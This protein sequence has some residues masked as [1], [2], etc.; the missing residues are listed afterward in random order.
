[1]RMLCSLPVALSLALTFMIPLASTSNVTSIWGIPRGAGAIPSRWN[2]PKVLQSRAIGRSPCSTWISTLGWLSAAVENTWLLRVGIV[3]L[4]SM[5]LVITPPRV[6]IP[7][8]RGTT[9][10]SSTS[11]TSPLSTPP[12]I[13]APTATTS[14]GLTPLDGA[15]PKKRSTICWIAGIRVEPPTRITSLMS[16]GVR[17]ASRRACSQGLIVLWIRSSHSCSNLA[18]LKVLTKCLGIP[19]TGIM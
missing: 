1:M 11:F 10:S 7:T 16:L 2:M 5:S 18:R 9:S 4:A 19:F 12:C 6:S 13:A 14:S 17:L 15:L 8:L 3:V